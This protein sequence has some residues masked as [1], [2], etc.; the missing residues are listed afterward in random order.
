MLKSWGS[1]APALV[2][3]F[4]LPHFVP[5]SYYFICFFVSNCLQISLFAN[6]LERVLSYPPGSKK[7]V[8]SLGSFFDR[9]P[10]CV[11]TLKFE[12][13]SKRGLGIGLFAG[14]RLNPDG[15]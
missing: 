15:L 11:A 12:Q 2:Y 5:F 6:L 3:F 10:P 9:A 4:F 14:L 13:G 1:G 7:R 8:P